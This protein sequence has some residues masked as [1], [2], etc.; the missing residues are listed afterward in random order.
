MAEKIVPITDPN[1]AAEIHR[2]L[3]KRFPPYKSDK[4]MDDIRYRVEFRWDVPLKH[5]EAGTYEVIGSI[6]EWQK[7]VWKKYTLGTKEW[8]DEQSFFH[9]WSYTSSTEESPGTLT[10]TIESDL[11]EA[12]SEV[13]GH[14]TM[15]LLTTKNFQIHFITLY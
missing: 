10:W 5:D 6:W 11:N 2:W 12:I 13:M 9:R 14:A 4:N 1:N 7:E 15:H 8:G 3:N